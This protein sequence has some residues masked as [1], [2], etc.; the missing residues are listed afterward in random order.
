MKDIPGNAEE[1]AEIKTVR[2]KYIRMTKIT[3]NEDKFLVSLRHTIQ[4]M[5]EKKSHS[6]IT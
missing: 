3:Q 4:Y 2:G 1:K 5:E 6:K